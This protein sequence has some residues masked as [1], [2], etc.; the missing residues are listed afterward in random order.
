MKNSG[1]KDIFFD[2]VKLAKKIITEKNR[3][4]LNCLDIDYFPAEGSTS[5]NQDCQEKYQ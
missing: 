2:I 1:L 5:W 4:I 3:E